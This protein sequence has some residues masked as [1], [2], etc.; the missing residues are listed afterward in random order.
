MRILGTA[1]ATLVALLASNA[2]V[3]AAE[4]IDPATLAAVTDIATRDFADPGAAVVT[5]VHKS[6]ARNGTG[7]C[8][9]VTLE[10]GAGVSVF[11]VLL[12]SAGGPSVLLAADYPDSD[13]SPNAATVRHLMNA[14]GCTE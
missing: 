4:I 8:G 9:E 1:V 14:F 12:E 5:G 7:Y 2:A 10:A 13:T 3:P 11:H 6:R